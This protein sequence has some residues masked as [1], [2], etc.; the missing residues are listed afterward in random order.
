MSLDL[1]EKREVLHECPKCGKRALAQI[2]QERF[3]CLWCGFRRN[4][5]ESNWGGGG[6][7]GAL[8]AVLTV[9]LIML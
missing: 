4:L 8:L 7:L 3:E 5:A 2:G 1:L 6:I 9:I